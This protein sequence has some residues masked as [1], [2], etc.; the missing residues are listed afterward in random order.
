[1]A[2]R[3]MLTLIQ[4]KE[5]H[6]YF[7]NCHYADVLITLSSKFSF[8]NL[9]KIS[10]AILSQQL[11]PNQAARSLSLVPSDV[12][13]ILK[14]LSNQMLS[15]CEIKESWHI[16]PKD[17]LILALKGFC[18]LRNNCLEFINQ[19]GLG[20]LSNMLDSIQAD[21]LK[22]TLSLL[23]QLSY[24][25][26]HEMG[27]SNLVDKIHHLSIDEGSN[28]LALKTSV[29]NCLLHA[30]PEGKQGSCEGEICSHTRY[31]CDVINLFACR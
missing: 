17:G 13:I 22:V 26:G 31:V 25:V 11:D 2:M 28:L 3:V 21:E 12:K 27:E 23:W 4:R 16:L 7:S 14:V 6:H 8:G 10:L 24:R 30:L 15:E 29:L 1:M 20:I 18:S 5:L 9:A 19:G